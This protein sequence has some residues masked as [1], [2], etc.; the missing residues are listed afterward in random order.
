MNKNR[1]TENGSQ[2]QMMKLDPPEKEETPQE[3]ADGNPQPIAGHI[4]RNPKSEPEKPEPEPEKPEHYF[5]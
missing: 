4:T 1:N 3:I 5:G 2:S